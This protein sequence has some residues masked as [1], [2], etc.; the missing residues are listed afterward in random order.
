MIPARVA[1]ENNIAYIL[2]TL[3]NTSVSQI[4]KENP[5]GLKMLQ[6]YL[7]NNE[8]SNMKLIRIAEQNG[9]DALVITV[10]GQVLGVR[11]K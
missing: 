4:A 9:F 8:K 7:S 2:S 10:D 6:L 5:K 11:R 3:T 1:S